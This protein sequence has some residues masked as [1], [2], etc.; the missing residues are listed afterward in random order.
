MEARKHSDVPSRVNHQH[1]TTRY[2]HG[3][4]AAF[5]K[6]DDFSWHNDTSSSPPARTSRSDYNGFHIHSRP[7]STDPAVHY[8]PT[9]ST[10]YLFAQS[11]L[12]S[13]KKQWVC[14]STGRILVGYAPVEVTLGAPS[15][16]H[17]PACAFR[18]NVSWFACATKIP[19]FPSALDYFDCCLNRA[20]YGCDDSY[21]N[22]C[23]S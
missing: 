1:A 22:R 5:K 7:R 9:Q 13:I 20:C 15:H 12:T 8:W 6:A 21:D 16:T 17:Q 3:S 19:N 4:V 11:R 14:S 18:A 10:A 23:L 2:E